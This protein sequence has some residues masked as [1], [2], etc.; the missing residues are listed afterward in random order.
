VLYRDYPGQVC[1]TARTLEVVGE[2]WSMLIIRDVFAGIRRYEDLQHS[3]GIARNIL[4]TRLMWLVD[5]GV[6][7]RRPYAG[8]RHEYV[9]TKKGRDLWPILMTMTTWGDRYY[10]EGGV[11]RIFRHKE[12]RGRIDTRLR[13]RKCGES[14]GP[15]D[16]YMEWGPSADAEM[17]EERKA[18]EA[19]ET[20]AA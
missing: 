4:Q 1:S 15:D 16:V 5:E 7:E 18:L 6:L 11:P 8:K 20:R 14:L 2:R 10:S 13:C 12:C 19:W 9:L 3:L 17:R